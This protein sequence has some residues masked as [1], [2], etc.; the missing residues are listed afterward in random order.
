MFAIKGIE[1]ISI[2]LKICMAILGTIDDLG[3]L[4]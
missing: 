1:N 3:L 4:S 2:F